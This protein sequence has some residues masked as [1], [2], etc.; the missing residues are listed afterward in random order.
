[1]NDLAQ[2]LRHDYLPG[3]KLKLKIVNKGN[4]AR[5]G[6]GYLK[7][8]TMVVVDEAS[9]LIGKEVEVDFVRFLQTSA[10]KMMFAKLVSKKRK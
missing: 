2:G 3:E 4:G 1:L 7:D 6:V 8:G 10:G 5:Q 9:G